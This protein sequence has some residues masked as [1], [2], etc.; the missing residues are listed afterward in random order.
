MRR[1]LPWGV[2]ALLVAAPSDALP[3]PRIA[4]G[5]LAAGGLAPQ[6]SGAAQMSPQT[7]REVEALLL[8]DAR[9]LELLLSSG[10]AASAGVSPHMAYAAELGA[11]EEA[12]RSTGAQ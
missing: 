9:E 4:A 5:E 8:R 11:R 10:I 7:A 6:G 2:T 1:V 12:L 3:A